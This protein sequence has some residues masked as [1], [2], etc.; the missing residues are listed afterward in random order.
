MLV[1][2]VEPSNVISDKYA[3]ST[4]ELKSGRVVTGRVVPGDYRLPHLEV[5]TDLLVPD[6]TIRIEKSDIVHRTAARV[7]AMPT[8][9][10]NTL[11]EDE[12][13]DL[14]AFL[15]RGEDQNAPSQLP[16]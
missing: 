6:A 11:R 9:L 8:G 14:L 7:S 4:F 12:I 10:L 5:V 2:I 15:I 3:A 16:H 1:S 13:L